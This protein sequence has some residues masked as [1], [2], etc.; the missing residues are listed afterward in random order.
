M[1]GSLSLDGAWKIRACDD[2]HGRPTHYVGP[3]ADLT[4]FVDA[5]VPGEVHLDL[6]RAG[7]IADTNLG[8]AVREA[9]WVEESVWVYR[10]EFDAPPEAL[11][12]RAVRLVFD[13]LDLDAKVYLNGEEV[14]RHA[15]AHT[16]CRID[17]AGKRRPGTNTVAVW[18]ESGL[19]AVCDR[20]ATAYEWWS[21]NHRLH[22]RAWLRKP[23]YQFGWD[24]NPRLINVGIW[25]PVR[26]EWSDTVRVDAVT[27]YSELADDHATATLHCRV[28]AENVTGE[29]LPAVVRAVCAETGTA[30]EL[31][32]ALPAGRSPQILAIP[33][34]A[35]KLWWPAGHGEQPLY[36]LDVEVRVGGEAVATAMRRT[37]IRTVTINQDPHPVE[38]RYFILEVNGRPIFLKGGNWVPPDMIYAR[39]TPDLCRRLIELAVEAN[40][41]MMRIWGGGLFA[42]HAM[43]DACD[44]R[45]VLVWHDFLY[46][47]AKYPADDFG[48]LR[49]AEAEAVFAIRDLSHHPSLA[50][51]CGNN[52]VEEGFYNWETQTEKPLV[53]FSLF[54][55]VLPI[56]L[57]REDPSRP[58][59]PGSPF[60]PDHDV[61]SSKL[62]GDQHPWAVTVGAEVD[63]IW[64]F[65]LDVSRCANEGGVLGASPAATVRGFLPPDQ[66]TMHSPAWVLHDNAVN[67]YERPGV[68]YRMME[69]WIGRVAT[70]MDLDDYLFYSAL[71]QA[72]GLKEYIDNFRR[73]MFSSSAAVFW[74]Y[75]DSWPTTHGWTIVDYHLRRKLSFHP[76]RRAFAPVTVVPAELP[77]AVGVF[78][79]NDTPAPWSGGLRYGLANLAGGLPLD[80]RA[81]VELPA[82]AAV[83]LARIPMA[84]WRQAGTRSAVAFALLLEGEQPIAQNRLFVEK[85]KDLE[86][87][88]PEVSVRR[89][90][91]LAVFSSPTFAWGV[92][93]DLD[94]EATLP[95]NAFDLLPG[96]DYRL[97]CPADRPLPQIVRIGNLPR[98][99]AQSSGQ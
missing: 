87:S 95:D 20:N 34:D 14:G 82:N 28:F 84:Q 63:N 65:R 54:H 83:E 31:D 90:G 17:V 13:G 6:M 55:H 73:R 7:I 60:S 2:L 26:L 10:R 29:D 53:Q 8:T 94:G 32:V 56:L 15:N 30:A 36:T 19:C 9:R 51:W 67:F 98:D 97:P 22:K 71:M 38:G 93:L 68:C 24:W 11:E 43:L 99:E 57:K 86:W 47:C 76:T 91:D 52:E 33:V 85:F 12:A 88:A 40:C 44:E 27:V 79:V 89:E 18:L 64:H 92:C 1:N 4:H 70:E 61:P 77:G 48:F 59:W 35:P 49:N 16:P 58:Y 21:L 72:E 96:I 42:D 74:M 66:Q 3:G 80:E 37:G 41:N 25:R 46:A 5:V 50:L 39:I 23:Q 81:A 62:S 78:G 45:G 75:N 69:T